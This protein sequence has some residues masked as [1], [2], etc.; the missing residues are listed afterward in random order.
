MP[1]RRRTPS[2]R[3]HKARKCGVVTIDGT[4]HYLGPSNSSESWERYR[5][6]AEWSANGHSTPPASINET[7]DLTVSELTAAQW[8][9]C[10]VNGVGKTPSR[11]DLG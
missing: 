7:P 9:I 1:R 3:L 11:T 2:Y 4:D 6:L 5:L 8:R 10:P